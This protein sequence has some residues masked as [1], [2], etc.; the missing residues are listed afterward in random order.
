MARFILVF[1]VL[2]VICGCGK[3]EVSPENYLVE[4]QIGVELIEVP[5]EV[6]LTDSLVV[7]LYG[8]IGSDGSYRFDHMETV[9]TDSLFEMTAFGIHDQTPGLMWPAMIIQWRGR[10]FVKLPPHGGG[11]VRVVFN[12]PDGSTVEELVAVDV[13]VGGI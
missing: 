10:E 12:Q 4:Y 6:A 8:F 9:E 2:L 11:V 3:D 5:L 13:E 7:R 1:S